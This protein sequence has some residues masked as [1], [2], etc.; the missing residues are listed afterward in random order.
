M[1]P[2]NVIFPAANETWHESYHDACVEI[3][4]KTR[5]PRAE[6]VLIEE[7]ARKRTL[8]IASALSE[9][10]TPRAFAALVQC[11]RLGLAS[12]SRDQ[13]H[14]TRYAIDACIRI[15]QNANT[16]MD[17]DA[18]TEASK[19]PTT[20][21][22]SSTFDWGTDYTSGRY[23]DSVEKLRTPQLIELAKERLRR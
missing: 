16:R 9:L 10:A 3:L 21:E 20:T 18:L 14:V 13:P 12:G 19:L 2:L 17:N 8:R 7:F 11:I 23:E 6:S 1:A 22:L 5:S 15:L 4:R